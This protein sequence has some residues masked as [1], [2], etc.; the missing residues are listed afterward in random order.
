MIVI[1]WP[2]T[3]FT[4]LNFDVQLYGHIRWNTIV[5]MVCT[6]VHQRIYDRILASGPTGSIHIF[7]WNREY[8]RTS[9]CYWHMLCMYDRM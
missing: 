5:Y 4:L 6:I 1:V 7:S 9:D 2:H 3:W 8:S